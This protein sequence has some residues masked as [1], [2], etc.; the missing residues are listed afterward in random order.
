[1]VAVEL[2]DRGEDHDAG[3]EK[4]PPDGLRKV[5]HEGDQLTKHQRLKSR[6]R[7]REGGRRE[8]IKVATK[9]Q[10]NTG[11]RTIYLC[12]QSSR[13]RDHDEARD[14]ETFAKRCIQ[15]SPQGCFRDRLTISRVSALRL[16]NGSIQGSVFITRA[17]LFAKPSRGEL[18]LEI[19]RSVL[20]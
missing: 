16:L 12:N 11:N 7:E 5:T 18:R 2:N 14:E 6:P 10:L 1:M 15:C 9:Y 3:P 19:L 4:A 13:V 17:L 20:R 8:N